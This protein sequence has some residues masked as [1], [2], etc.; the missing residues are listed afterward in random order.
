MARGIRENIK[1]D[2]ILS[3]LGG[4]NVAWDPVWEEVFQ[5]QPWGKYPA[6][7]LIRFVARNFYKAPDRGQIK[8]L[9][10]GCGPGANLW[11]MAREGFTVYG[12]DGSQ[13]AVEIAK[14]RLNNECQ[15]WQGQFAVGDIGSLPF[16]DDVFDAVIDNEAVYANPYEESKKIY[17]E[18]ARVTKPGGKIFSRTFAAGC[19][20]DKTGE[21][22]G[23]NAWMVAEGPLFQKGYSRFVDYQEIE[24]LFRGFR[25]EQVESIAR[26][27]ENREHEIK[28]WIIY[29]KK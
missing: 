13:T 25:I 1:Q 4:V 8:I 2:I 29:G 7:D 10:V 9:E 24:D 20:G 12:I 15:G 19:W 16:A 23:H 22:V 26:T 5:Q 11:Y 21:K 14:Q 17:L 27:M 18:M 3:I 6:E 28:E